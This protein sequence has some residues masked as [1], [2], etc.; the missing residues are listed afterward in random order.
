MVNAPP[1]DSRR[2]WFVANQFHSQQEKWQVIDTL[3]HEIVEIH[4]IGFGGER[5]ARPL[6]PGNPEINGAPRSH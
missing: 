1:V 4:F 2:G 3:L 6:H 5:S